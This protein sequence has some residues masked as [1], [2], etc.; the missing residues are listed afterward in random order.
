MEKQEYNTIMKM[1]NSENKS[2]IKFAF[3]IIASQKIEAD[4]VEIFLQNEWEFLCDFKEL[5]SGEYTIVY[6]KIING[7]LYTF[8]YDTLNNKITKIPSWI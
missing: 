2:D 5:Y 3:D 1:I 4:I 8:W 7:K 6:K